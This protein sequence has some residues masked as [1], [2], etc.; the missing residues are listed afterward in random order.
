MNDPDYNKPPSFFDKFQM[1]QPRR[2]SDV[3]TLRQEFLQ[4]LPSGLRGILEKYVTK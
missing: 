4:A 1:P 2:A 3:D